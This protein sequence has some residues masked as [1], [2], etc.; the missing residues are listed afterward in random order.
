MTGAA[1]RRRHPAPSAAVSTDSGWLRLLLD[2][3]SPQAFADYRQR[4][5]VGGALDGAAEEQ[6][7]DAL[8]LRELLEQRRRKATELAALYSI[9]GRLVSVTDVDLLLHEIVEQAK[10]LLHVDLAYLSLIDGQ[11][12]AIEVAIGQISSHLAGLTMPVE[13]GFSSA[14]LHSGAPLWTSDYRDDR[15]FDHHKL[16]DTAA[17]REDI[18][19]LLGVPM[20]VRGQVIGVLFAAKRQERT[21]TADEIELLS[22]LA[23]YAAT[24]LEN[25]RMLAALR[26]STSQLQA[27]NDQLGAII[28]W[29]RLL[30]Q[31]V[32]RGGDAD[33]LLAQV[34][35]KADCPAYFVRS[36]ADLP[37]ELHALD[38][39]VIAALFAPHSD[40]EASTEFNFGEHA[41][42]VM[43]VVAAGDI[44]GVLTL[45][46]SAGQM[47]P[48]HA[49]ILE[50]AAPTMALLLLG[51]RS[52]EEAARKTR[53]GLLVDLLTRSAADKR[54]TATHAR[55]LGLDPARR[56]IVAVFLP[57][58]DKNQVR[59]AVDTL[60]LP[61]GSVVGEYGQRIIAVIP[62]SDADAVA[63]S[64]S[65]CAD[66]S[67]T[68]GISAPAED[69]AGLRGCFRDAAQTV[70]VMLTLDRR[71]EVGTSDRLGLYRIL[72]SQGGPREIEQLYNQY[73]GAVRDEES[74]SGVPLLVTL[75]SFLRNSQ[76]HS[77]TAAELNI[78]S[79]T[80]YQRL[81]KLNKIL[82]ERWREPEQALDLQ[83]V[84]RLKRSAARLG[85]SVEL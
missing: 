2:E 26:S 7:N 44:L 21:F 73:L 56:H 74:R 59:R 18:R 67:A 35:R 4:L 36:V 23:A 75:E 69:V 50:R 19:G 53:D 5:Q 46:C 27:A 61:L 60:A 29:D 64:L 72:L 57:V 41:I 51:Q 43:P 82:G 42:R 70:D 65:R 20:S 81:D 37:P 31:T 6:F 63:R 45:V 66:L 80:L 85:D 13:E 55:L 54:E 1:E 10:N 22:S 30:T 16:A 12:I 38:P 78:H 14:V 40:S 32:L 33:E 8:A 47:R 39:A 25:S 24:A 15:R 58:E 52:A 62:E 83:L 49:M 17:R 68:V 77:P 11:H 48:D 9:A 79:N 71:G 84:L 34:T 76:R 28:D 3:A